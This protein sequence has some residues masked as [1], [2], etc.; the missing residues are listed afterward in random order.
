MEYRTIKLLLFSQYVG[1]SPAVLDFTAINKVTVIFQYVGESPAVLGESGV[2][3]QSSCSLL[4]YS[5]SSPLYG[6]PPPFPPLFNSPD[7]PRTSRTGTYQSTYSVTRM[8]VLQRQPIENLY[9][10]GSG[11][12]LL[13][14]CCRRVK[15]WVISSTSLLSQC[16]NY[17]VNLLW[18]DGGEIVGNFANV[19]T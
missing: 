1:Q 16:R 11:I 4:S 19:F 12:T 10:S 8:I 5:P 13:T 14:H 3:V 2:G 15:Q 7:M 18:P 6:A 17:P 9:C